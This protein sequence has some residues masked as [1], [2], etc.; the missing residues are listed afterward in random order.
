MAEVS[1]RGGGTR[2][3]GG[4]RGGRGGFRGTRNPSRSQ[5]KVDDQENMASTSADED[6]GEVGDLVKQYGD[7]VSMVKEV[8]P[9]WSK[10]DVVYALNETGGDVTETISRILDGA[11]PSV[12]I[13]I[14]ACL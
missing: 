9:D 14:F 10:E 4:Y 5:H 8:C 13:F 1:S 3:R 11:L 12:N 6:Q 2:G 7:K